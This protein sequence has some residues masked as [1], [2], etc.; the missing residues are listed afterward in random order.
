MTMSAEA[1]VTPELTTDGI[2]STTVN[3]TVTESKTQ[4]VETDD[5]KIA[6]EA[7][8]V[9]AEAETKRNRFRERLDKHKSR[10]EKA[11]RRAKELEAKL[12]ALESAKQ[13]HKPIGEDHCPTLAECDWDE[14]KH[15]E[16][17]RKYAERQVAK[18][19]TAKQQEEE[20][21]KIELTVR[22]QQQEKAEAWG[23]KQKAASAKYDD[24]DD[25]MEDFAEVIIPPAIFDFISSPDSERGAEMALY[26][27][28]NVEEF[29][30]L[31]KLSPV[32]Q[33]AA[34]AK[35]EDKLDEL[36][37]PKPSAAPAP[38]KPIGG[39]ASANSEPDPKTHPKEWVI[40]ERNR[41]RKKR[42]G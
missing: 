8:K 17:T 25:V 3:K 31:K 33:I 1:E 28:R 5:A 23:A 12:E 39:K 10:A 18:Q 15:A 11:E 27:G 41:E 9:K 30:K 19:L 37:A 36:L 42:G 21:K 13:E 14:E 2:E 4:T 7:E 6:E 26:L 34:L 38:P 40:W 16:E 24:F 29:E 20:R 22:Q 32:R 35:L